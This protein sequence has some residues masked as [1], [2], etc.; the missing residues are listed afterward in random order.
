MIDFKVYVDQICNSSCPF[1][2]KLLFPF[3]LSAAGAK[4]GVRSLPM[5]T[6]PSRQSTLAQ[7]AEGR[8]GP[9]VDDDDDDNDDP[10]LKLD[11]PQ[12]VTTSHLHSNMHSLVLLSFEN[13]TACMYTDQWTFLMCVCLHMACV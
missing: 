13:M 2:T 7:P 4:R 9:S 8:P 11:L 6:V 12:G 3:E 5:R 10:S 1:V